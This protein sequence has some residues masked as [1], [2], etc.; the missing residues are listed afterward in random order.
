MKHFLI[1]YHRSLGLMMMRVFQPDEQD[2][3]GMQWE[4]DRFR[5][6]P[7]PDVSVVLLHAESLVDA[8]AAHSRYFM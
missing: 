5:Y 6:L 1:I 8:V 4:R 2:T 3:A 7:A